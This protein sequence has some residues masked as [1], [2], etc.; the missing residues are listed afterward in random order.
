MSKT[1]GR[2]TM[3][4]IGY[5][6]KLYGTSTTGGDRTRYKDNRYENK[7]DGVVIDLNHRIVGY[8]KDY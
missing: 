6:V 5:L 4:Q 8:A 1:Q 3:S 2:Y 7:A